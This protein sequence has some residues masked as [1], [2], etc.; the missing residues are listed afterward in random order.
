M[1]SRK[2]AISPALTTSTI[3]AIHKIVMVRTRFSAEITI[4]RWFSG[5]VVLCDA[6]D[7]DGS[8]VAITSVALGIGGGNHQILDFFQ[9]PV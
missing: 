1:T 8:L 9:I 6:T 3:W 7:E 5:S 2:I 4:F